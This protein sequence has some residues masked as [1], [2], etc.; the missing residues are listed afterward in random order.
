MIEL[1]GRRQI[2][3]P[4]AGARGFVLGYSALHSVSYD[5]SVKTLT[6]VDRSHLVRS[7][8]FTPES[9][10]YVRSVMLTPRFIPIKS[11]VLSLCFILTAP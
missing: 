11:A 10:C 8:R 2:G 7:K 4:P 9:M 1:L 6:A 5:R 3:L